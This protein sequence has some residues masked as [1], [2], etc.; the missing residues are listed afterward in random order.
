MKV[1]NK[2]AY[3]DY[4]ILDE[5]EVGIVLTGAEAKS[6]RSGRVI[7][8]GSF[9]KVKNGQMMLFNLNIP[10][11]QAKQPDNLEETRTRVLLASKKQIDEWGKMA[12]GKGMAIALLSLF[13]KRNLVKAKVGLGKGKREF[14]KRDVIKKRQF[15]REKERMIRGKI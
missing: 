5:M 15:E 4:Q 3:R 2:Y 14:E 12:T 7:M 6:I 9:V 8:R 13:T 1:I 11:Y 10:Q